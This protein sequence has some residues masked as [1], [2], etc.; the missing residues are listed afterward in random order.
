MC[1]QSFETFDHVRATNV[2]HLKGYKNNY[3]TICCCTCVVECSLTFSHVNEWVKQ[4]SMKVWHLLMQKANQ[5][6]MRVAGN[7]KLRK[8]RCGLDLGL[9]VH[10]C[11]HFSHLLDLLM[12]RYH[13]EV[14]FFK[15]AQLSLYIHVHTHTSSTHSL[16][17][18]TLNCTTSVFHTGADCND[19]SKGHTVLKET[20]RS[21]LFSLPCTYSVDAHLHGIC[22]SPHL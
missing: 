16:M 10:L 19:W 9:Q 21:T 18:S 12:I 1:V 17:P 15:N 20:V 14:C 6:F 22:S 13:G 5:A 4:Q 3:F 2:N 8:G 7:T 11:Q